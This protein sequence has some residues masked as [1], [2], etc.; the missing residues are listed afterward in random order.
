M[1]RKKGMP[2]PSHLLV[3]EKRCRECLY[4]PTKIVSGERKQ[5]VIESC[6]RSG[7]YFVCHKGSMTGNNQLCCRGFYDNEDTMFLRLARALK[8]V[9]FI[10]VP[11]TDSE[12]QIEPQ[13][14]AK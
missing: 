4:S 1:T 12:S 3:A 5:Q 8:R 13:V 7:T 2:D 14:P 11:N 10:P 9:K 6:H